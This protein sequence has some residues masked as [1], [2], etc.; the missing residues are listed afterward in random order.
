MPPD[1]PEAAPPQRQQIWDL[2]PIAPI[3]T[4][5]Q[6][7]GVTCPHCAAL[8]Y[9]ALPPTVPPGTCGP[10]VVALVG[11]LHGRYRLSAR[12]VVVLL[13]AVFGLELSL[14][15][16]P[17][18]CATVS[19]AL[20]PAYREVAAAVQT[21]DAV[22]AD[23]TSWA[24]AGI[25]HWLWVVVAACCTLL[26]VSRHRDRA[27]LQRMLGITFQG[28][29]GS[30]RYSA[31]AGRDPTRRQI[32]WAHLQRNLQAGAEHGG[33]AG[34]WAT[35]LLGQIAVL[36]AH[37]HAYQ[38][39][40]IAWAAL[41]AALAPVQEQIRTLLAAGREQPLAQARALSTELLARWPAL[42]TLARVVGVEPTNNRAERALRP[43]VLWRKGCFGAQ[44][45]TGNQFVERM[46]TVSATCQQQGRALWPFVAAAVQAYWSK[47]PPPQLLPSP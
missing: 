15:S 10:Q 46:L 41:P 25:K 44:S 12:E 22:N 27:S 17:A 9:G 24:Q 36:F 6:L 7:L 8:V 39:G 32:C 11:L 3:V 13:G 28:V 31:Y 40:E 5:H 26:L 2:P 1:S 4:A 38:A 33:A 42:W 47:E 30:D 21:A 45:A 43:A 16:V 23:E 29:V 35:A 34:D 37:W 18:C 14:G 19:A 20:A